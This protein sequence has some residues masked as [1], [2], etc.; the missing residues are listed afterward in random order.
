MSEMVITPTVVVDTPPLNP[1]VVNQSPTV[2]VGIA[3]QVV[4]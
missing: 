2:N 1:E 4:S 3:T